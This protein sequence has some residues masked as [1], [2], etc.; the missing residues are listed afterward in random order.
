LKWEVH[1]EI[2][3][4]RISH[5]LFIIIRVSK[6]FYVTVWKMLYYGFIYPFLAHGIIVWGQSVKV[7]TR[8]IFTLQKR[9]VRHMAKLKQLELCKDS[10]RQLKILPVHSLY[11][12]EKIL[13]E[14][15]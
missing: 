7:L 1:I 5:N 11:I 2:T 9:A 4:I 3:Y 8:R 14:K 15:M 12:Q 6:I 13:Y 10:L